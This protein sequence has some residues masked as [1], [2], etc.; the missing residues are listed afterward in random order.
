[1]RSAYF[2]TAFLAVG[3]AMT[4]FG[5]APEAGGGVPARGLREFRANTF[6][7]SAQEAPAI[8]R[9]R[10]G[11]MTVVW[12]SRRQNDGRYGIFLQRFD[13]DGAALGSETR[14]SLGVAA[15]ATN[16]D[17][18]VDSAGN[19]W[20]VWQ[21]HGQDGDGAGIIA[22]RFDRDF[23]GGSEL[24][25]NQDTAG[26]QT[27]PVLATSAD[28]QVAVAWQSLGGA[29]RASRVCA[30]VF[31]A[32]GA[33]LADEMS[34]C[35][36]RACDVAFAA[37]G[38]L[39]L[40]YGALDVRG[41]PDGVVV[42]TLD[43]AARAIGRPLRV[44]AGDAIEPALAVSGARALLTWVDPQVDGSDYGVVAT[45]L[46][47]D[48]SPVGA[49][50]VVNETTGGPQTAATAIGLPDGGFAIA[51]NGPDAVAS[52]V[53]VRAYSAD[54]AARG[55]ERLLNQHTS[56][57]QRMRTACATSRLVAGDDGRI[58]AVW[59]GDGGLGDAQGVHVSLAAPRP[60]ART[61]RAPGVTP[62]MQPS[63]RFVATA[64]GP[65]PHI[66]PTFDPQRAVHAE[67][68]ISTA[69]GQIGFTGVVD[70]G[71]TPPDPHMAV[72]PSHVVVMTNGNISFIA[73]DGTL[74]FSDEI[75]D[76]FGFWGSVGA[77]GFVFD[78]EVVYDELSG[79]FFA[80]A[81][82]AFVSGKS[83]VLMAVSD[84]SDPN[85]AWFKYR[86]ETTLE[87]GDLFDS[88]NIGVDAQAVYVTGDAFPPGASRYPLYVFN[89]A[90]MLA[91]LPV[92]PLSRT[93]ISTTTQSAGIPPVSFDNPP[94]L[95]LI[96]HSEAASASTVRL[97]AITN[98]LGTP[99][100]TT[101]TLTVPSYTNPPADP[102]QMGTTSR[103]ELFDARFWRSAYRNGSLWATH[104]VGSTR[105]LARWYEFAMNGWPTSGQL[106]ALV[107]SGNV[108]LGPTVSTFFSAITVDDGGNAALT[109]A[110]SSSTSF[111]SMATASRL[112]CDPL[113]T[114]GAS[115]S[116]KTNTAGYSAGRWGDYAAVEVDPFDGKTLWAH[117]E[118]AI[119]QSWRTWVQSFGGT[120]ADCNTNGVSDACD[121]AAGTSQDSDANGVPDECDGPCNPADLN[122]DGVV[123][124]SDLGTV[125]ASFGQSGPG[126]PGDIDGDDDVDL[127]DLGIMLSNFG[128]QC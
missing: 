9:D 77:T 75:E 81:A 31:G 53:Y 83:Y 67:R 94:A 36:G 16:P 62:E 124:L 33:P 100:V 97:I 102:P 32:N 46:E 50:F 41:G 112:S 60:F 25:V 6:V 98:Q 12:A 10:D 69:R 54:G 26:D 22:R 3:S 35:G 21:S 24:L 93:L 74:T 42:Q 71:W 48:G 18:G 116:H 104:H 55:G 111:I 5:A 101:T 29:E 47:L 37:D 17:V 126:L 51:W 63:E 43:F 120:F 2:T 23:V 38:R 96:E 30:R 128:V 40:A 65:Q 89:K 99:V 66:P 39:L 7:R 106:P 118:Y 95:Y 85:G 28:G 82:E 78:P 80:M 57:Q 91:G 68:E 117:H 44:A 103:P 92:T 119:G 58:A 15:H 114:M 121:I 87:S 105:S 27:E 113:G 88:P 52:G 127:S 1:M 76:S 61:A 110:R 34:L 45:L 84:D 59:S 90:S 14:A 8:A 72:G 125:L 108:D 4:A 107:Q 123:D 13:A 19:T 20:V 70:T 49:Q 64:G 11:S 115:T 56:G 122:N 79:R 86:I 109:F 73:K